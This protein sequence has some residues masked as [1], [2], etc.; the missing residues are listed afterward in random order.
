M[1]SITESLEICARQLLSFLAFS[2]PVVATFVAVFLGV[3]LNGVIDR[4]REREKEVFRPLSD[5]VRELNDASPLRPIRYIHENGTHQSVSFDI[6]PEVFYSVDRATRSKILEYQE[7]VKQLSILADTTVSASVVLHE[8]GYGEFLEDQLPEEMLMEPDEGIGS[9]NAADGLGPHIVAGRETVI[10]G[11]NAVI[12]S[13]STQVHGDKRVPLLPL[14]VENAPLL[15]QAGSSDELRSF[16][17]SH[18]EVDVTY[19]DERCPNWVD[20]LWD[21]LQRPWE[22]EAIEYE[23]SIFGLNVVPEDQSHRMVSG[24]DFRSIL[25]SAGTALELRRLKQRERVISHAED[26]HEMLLFRL[27]I[28]LYHPKRILLARQ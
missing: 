25:S 23:N 5:E 22:S 9:D 6:R 8:C 16:F 1:V 2:L 19:L 17:E 18:T 13:S 15:K 12:P 14:L 27:S 10:S 28:P 24:E 26:L 4:E 21:T 3:Y 7:S 11:R 20:A